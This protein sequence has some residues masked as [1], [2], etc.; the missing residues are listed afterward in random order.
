MN[1]LQGRN[2]AFDGCSGAFVSLPV[3]KGTSNQLICN[4]DVLLDLI[5]CKVGPTVCYI[6]QALHTLQYS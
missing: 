4:I 6:T 5:S 2:Y 3:I 1:R